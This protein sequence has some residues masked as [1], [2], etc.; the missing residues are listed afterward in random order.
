MPSIHRSSPV[1]VLGLGGL[2]HLA[3]ALAVV[4]ACVAA[5]SLWIHYE[6]EPWTRD[7]RVRSEVV[8]VAPDVAGLVDEIPV[9]DNQEVTRG[10]T[11]LVIDRSRYTLALRQAEA[12]VATR[13][14]VVA[15][16]QREDARNH[17][18]EDLV[19]A[20]V[21]EQGLSRLEQARASLDE[22][23]A[24]RD[25]CKLDLE[26]ATVK[27]PVDG[28]ITNLELRVG[29]YVSPGK[30]AMALVERGSFHVDG[31]FEET[32]LARIHPGAPVTIR[33]MGETA[34]LHGHV[35]SIASGIEDRER[36]S[37]GTLLPNVNPTF[38]WVRLPQRIPVR[39][40]LDDVAPEIRLVA[41][42][43][44]TVMLDTTRTP[45]ALAAVTANVAAENP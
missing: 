12:V 29:D 26:R 23:L 38:A 11:L 15:Q 22:A 16:A 17:G 14:A 13:R 42:R 19:A 2:R 37:S 5:R 36:T 7:G 24:R 34:L 21:R 8:L 40:A 1:V 25:V 27:A 6:V 43:T 44:A 35:D 28:A 39:I 32:K 20:E 18:L 9:R 41:G 3:T 33:L 30:Q 31:Y 45:F 10:Q 4:A